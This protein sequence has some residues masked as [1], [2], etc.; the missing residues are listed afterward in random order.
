MYLSLYASANNGLSGK[1]P[2]TCYIKGMLRITLPTH[3]GPPT[4]VL[5]GKLA[6]L[7]VKE[8]ILLTR[9]LEPGTP[10]IFNIED[11][12]YVDSLGEET[13]QSLSK[14]GAT[15][16]AENVYGKD[17]CQR[18]HLHRTTKAK[19]GVPN[20]LRPKAEKESTSISLPSSQPRSTPE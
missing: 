13:L 4:F 6:G 19:A 2:Q 11:V 17:L 10:A 5:E 9:H 16:I 20:R 18:L 3:K 7:W 8:F 14:Q 1:W 12:L 15:F